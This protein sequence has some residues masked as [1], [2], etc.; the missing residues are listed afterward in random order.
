ML[1][2]QGLTVL[3]W[4]VYLKQYKKLFSLSHIIPLLFFLSIVG[5]YL[6]LY[7]FYDDPAG[8]VINLFKES[9]QRSFFEYSPRK[10]TLALIDFPIRLF[11]QIMAPW[12]LLLPFLFKKNFIREI[13]ANPL[14][15]FS[16]LVLTPNIV[17][18]WL[19]PGVKNRYLYPF[20]PFIVIIIA[21]FYITNRTSYPHL[22]RYFHWAVKIISVIVLLTLFILPFISPFNSWPNQWLHI[23]TA[24][25]VLFLLL[26]FQKTKSY[27]VLYLTLI[28]LLIKIDINFT[29]LK[30]MQQNSIYRKKSK[31]VLAITGDK[32]IYL[33]GKPNVFESSVSI[34]SHTWKNSQRKF[35]TP[36]LIHYQIPY[37][38]TKGNGNIMKYDPDPEN[39]T[40]YMAWESEIDTTAID[41]LYRYTKMTWRNEDMLLFTL[42]E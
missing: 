16:F 22:K 8:F 1:V 20:L 29:Y 6:Y 24:I 15:M 34:G 11:V 10:I 5:I 12:F 23:V 38:I 28:I 41:I 3:V 35:M 18:Y 40:F 42:K 13:K 27:P 9:S 39:N 25:I 32:P 33:T 4:T 30:G 36:P 26:L 14:L 17:F 37:Y 31:E 2:F 19:T 7:S 21:H